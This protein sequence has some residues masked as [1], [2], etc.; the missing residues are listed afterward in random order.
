MCHG[1]A[2]ICCQVPYYFFN[3]PP[4]PCTSVVKIRK[5]FACPSA[6][7]EVCDSGEGCRE[8]RFWW[9][10]A[11]GG[12]WFTLAA[13][14][15]ARCHVLSG[16][17]EAE[18]GWRRTSL[19][20]S[21]PTA[22]HRGRRVRLKAKGRRGRCKIDSSRSPIWGI[23]G[24]LSDMSRNSPHSAATH[25]FGSQHSLYFLLYIQYVATFQHS[26]CIIPLQE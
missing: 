10:L 23:V 26:C 14:P 11:G 7:C 19:R 3:P 9:A 13:L 4:S 1:R 12:I 24:S 21:P 8:L 5:Y 15:D 25:T 16:E 17:A 20:P 18:A 6:D 2:L 22:G